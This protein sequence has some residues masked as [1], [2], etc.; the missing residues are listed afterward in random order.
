MNNTSKL[1]IKSGFTFFMVLTLITTSFAVTL[2]KIPEQIDSED[3]FATS[4]ENWQVSGRNGSSTS[5]W[6][7]P[8][9]LDSTDNVGQSSSLAIDSNDN[10]HVSYYD[11][12]NG[13]LDYMTYDGTSWSVPVSLDSTDNVGK[14]SSLAIN[15]NDRLYISY[16]DSTNGN[17]YYIS[18]TSGSWNTPYTID[19]TDDV[20]TQPSLAIDS[21]DDL[22]ITASDNT[23]DNLDYYTLGSA[24][25]QQ[26][27]IAED[28]G[29]LG[30]KSSL[31]IDSNDILHV[32]YY[33]SGNGDL[34]YLNSSSPTQL[35]AFGLPVALDSTDDVGYG[36]SLAIDSNDNLHVTYLDST[37]GNLEYMMHNGTSWSTPVSID[38]TDSV[39]NESSLA[40]DSNDNLHVTYFDSTNGNLE[41][42][43]HNGTSWSTPISLDSTDNVGLD[44]SLAVD[45]NDNLHVTY[46]DFTNGNLEYI[47][48]NISTSG[49][50][51]GGNNTGGNNTGGNNTGGNNTGGND[52]GGNDT[53]DPEQEI[54]DSI[55][56]NGDGYING[57]ELIAYE[58]LVRSQ[59][60][61][62]AMDSAEE[63]EILS[64][65]ADYDNGW[66]SSDG[67]DTEDGNDSMLEFNEFIPFYEDHYAPELVGFAMYDGF[68]H[69]V[70]YDNTV[71]EQGD[72][73]GY[74]YVEVYSTENSSWNMVYSSTLN[75]STLYFS[76]DLE[77]FNLAEDIYYVY[78][79]LYNTD[80][81]L[82]ATASEE[83]QELDYNVIMFDFY[84]TDMSGNISLDEFLDTL[85]NE[86]TN[87]SEEPMDNSTRNM[88]S[89]MFLNEDINGDEELNL[90]EFI[91]FMETLN[92]DSEDEDSE[93][94]MLMIILD[95]DG[96]GNITLSEILELVD[97]NEPDAIRMT[98][99]YTNIFNNNDFDSNEMLDEDEFLVFFQ[100]VDLILGDFCYEVLAGDEMWAE[101]TF[102]DEDGNEIDLIPGD[103]APSD[104][105]YCEWAEIS[106]QG[107]LYMLDTDGDGELSLDEILV[108]IDDED[109]TD[110]QLLMIGWIFESSDFDGSQYLDAD[111]FSSFMWWMDSG[112]EYFPTDAQLMDQLFDSFDTNFDSEVTLSETIAFINSNAD[113]GLLST[114]EEEYIVVLLSIH[115]YDANGFIDFIE[116]SE[117]YDALEEGDGM[118]DGDGDGVVDAMDNCPLIANPTQTDADGDGIGTA[119]D[120]MENTGDNNTGDNITDSTDCM[121]WNN[122]DCN[123]EFGCRDGLEKVAIP[124]IDETTGEI[125]LDADGN[126]I[127][128][129][130]CEGASLE[131]EDE[132]EDDESSG[133]LPSIGVIATLGAIAVSFV[134]VIR[135]EQEE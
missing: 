29:I 84:D 73:Y 117:F 94:E 24:W 26:T 109:E 104:G 115:D 132:D 12:T 41:Y 103:S 105:E 49:N 135:R 33:N 64:G 8:V 111:E 21:N 50:N 35:T 25:S 13:D 17:L 48:T 67:E 82:I 87:N 61:E 15:S 56:T 23:Y 102:E 99:F 72:D 45:S 39:G 114:G 66:M 77:L 30:E 44:S 27:T 123:E 101:G 79:K 7:T 62:S 96:N 93:Y 83:L 59:R 34:E 18:G 5:S 9:S 130:D 1:K 126:E 110:E 95:E 70:I 54:F 38:S 76:L 28:S 75:S 113:D 68:L 106:S 125:M 14:F 2:N 100:I 108:S 116:F 53:S 40:I 16:Y 81:G 97:E 128:V 88:F 42:I 122:A 52:T 134:A 51:T 43:M 107:L 127:E 32:T 3:S 89:N 55:D 129:W 78:V 92:S 22:H 71:E 37:N 47:T 6:S 58:N 91:S 112:E 121:P 69:I 63:S 31:A 124:A 10:L 120:S 19:Y 85:D 57:T 80:D 131:D 65:L 36:S 133:G 119:C 118:G 74:A 60:N 20:G 86:S 46:Y 98:T 90:D 11:Y 4:L